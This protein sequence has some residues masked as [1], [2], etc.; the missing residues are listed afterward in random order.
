MAVELRAT[1]LHALLGYADHALTVASYPEVRTVLLGGLAELVGADSVTLTHLDLR[2]GREVVLPWPLAVPD[3]ERVQRYAAVAASHPLRPQLRRLG[4]RSPAAPPLRISDV[5]SSRSWRTTPLYRESH[6]GIADQMALA[7]G[8][9]GTA[10]RAVTLSRFTGRFTDRQQELLGRTRVHLR[11][12]V[13]RAPLAGQLG[14]QIAPRLDRVPLADAPGL[15]RS[16]EEPA[17][18]LSGRERQVL[19]LVAQGLTDVQVARRLQLSPATV[20]RHLHRIYVRLEL[21]NRAAAV[22]HYLTA[23][24]RDHG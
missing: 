22:Q 1:E 12:A 11:H 7:L 3:P 10:V 6:R 13:A 18:N 8:V 21:P 2:N 5:L 9:S 14:I 20:S 17:A 16:D 4:T 19:A 23:C 24:A 15:R